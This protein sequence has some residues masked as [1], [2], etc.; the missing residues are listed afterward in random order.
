MLL[1]LFLALSCSDRNGGDRD[2]GPGYDGPG[3]EAWG[4]VDVTCATAADC[5]TGETCIENVCQVDTCSSG[6]TETSAPIGDSLTFFEEMEV[7]FADTVEWEGQ[8]PVDQYSGDLD[9]EGS[10]KA[11]PYP[12]TGMGGGD[13]DG[14]GVGG[15]A[16]SIEGSRKVTVL[17]SGET[18]DVGFVPVALDGGD[19]DA[20]GV[21]ELVAISADGEVSVCTGSGCDTYSFGDSGIG[22]LDIAVGDIDG[23]TFDEIVLLLSYDGYSVLYG[24]NLDAE[25]TGQVESYWS[26][27][28][29]DNLHR[30]TVGDLDGDRVEEVIGLRQDGCWDYCDDSMM[31]WTAV[32]GSDGGSLVLQYDEELDGIATAIDVAAADTDFNE[33]AD[34]VILADDG[35]VTLA[36]EGGSGFYVRS[37]LFDLDVSA[38][39]NFVAMADHD[40]DS[41]RAEL[42]GEEACEGSVMPVMVLLIPPY[43]AEYSAAPAFAGFGD[44]ESTSETWSD[45]VSL[46]LHV[47]VGASV[48]FMDAFGA[49]YST[50]V[51]ERVTIT[52]SLGETTG[53]GARYFLEGDPETYGN[54]YGGVVLAWG[55]FDAYKYEIDDPSKLMGDDGESFVLTVPNGGGM[56]IWST[57]RYNAMAE[58]VGLPTIEIPY[59]VGDIDSYPTT[60][61]D[62]NGDPIPDDKMVFPSPKSYIASDVG[63]V[64]WWSWVQEDQTNTTNLDRSLGVSAGVSAFGVKV[65]G[66][67]EFGW[68]SG[69][70]LRVGKNAGFFGGVHPVPDNPDTPEDEYAQHV[71]ELTPVV[72][73]HDYLTAD[74]EEAAHYVMTYTAQR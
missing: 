72:Y 44:T 56:S 10:E 27:G 42:V 65:G 58:A 68:G 15:Y 35:K 40:G 38:A 32:D 61:E 22:G 74:G 25:M 62:L 13:F 5:L 41:P 4:D 50:R 26:D 39:P 8:Y 43:D 69:Y 20:D 71:Y 64:M 33:R 3:S 49:E 37:A 31:S 17:D 36:R 46:G 7:A 54:Q 67:V 9:Y 70:S 30:I 21:S 52:E 16:V 2:R 63:K 47:D 24:M 59:T 18:V 73:M 29:D 34:I 28:H 57:P 12:I 53:V 19:I 55:C 60:P 51:S 48:K 6:L 23:D 1:T 11:T 66:G 14:D 45:T